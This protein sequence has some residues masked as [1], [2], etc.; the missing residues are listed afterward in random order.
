MFPGAAGLLQNRGHRIKGVAASKKA[1]GAHSGWRLQRPGRSF[2]ML[3]GGCHR[4]N[5]LH[6][7]LKPLPVS[8]MQQH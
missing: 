5:A 6:D 7:F 2:G 1:S 4:V 8:A 3:P